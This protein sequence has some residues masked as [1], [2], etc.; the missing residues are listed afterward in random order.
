MGKKK[1][2]FINPLIGMKKKGDC[3]NN[4]LK[5][6][7]KYLLKM[8]LYKSKV[9]YGPVIC[10]MNYAGPREA[11]HHAYIRE[12]L[13]FNIF[14]IGRDHAGAENNYAP[15]DSVKFVK[16]NKN[17]L[18]INIFYHEGAYFCKKCKKIVLK[19]DCN[20][21]N[22]ENISGSEFREKLTK[23]KT[24]L[25]TRINLQKHIN[26]FNKDLFY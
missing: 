24:F 8:K 20:H 6:I 13:G 15:L 5:D 10:N 11:I 21:K 12:N 18:K 17:R 22:L 4:V 16:K 14:S 2:L 23:G 3:K 25:Y 7:Y 9:I 19:G 26:K 1:I